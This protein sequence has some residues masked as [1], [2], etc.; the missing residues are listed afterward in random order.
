MGW[1]WRLWV[2]FFLV[3]QG[4]AMVCAG[5]ANGHTA[6]MKTL[7][8][9]VSGALT[10]AFLLGFCFRHEVVLL[11]N[12]RLVRLD[13]L[14]GEASYVFVSGL[15]QEKRERAELEERERAERAEKDRKAALPAAAV[16]VA[17]APGA[18]TDAKTAT[19]DGRELTA[20]EI[21]RL[22]FKWRRN[23]SSDVALSFHNPF[24][25]KVRID[26]VRVQIPAHDGRAAIDRMYE[27]T[28]FACEPLADK[29]TPL[30]TLDIDWEHIVQA[31]EGAAAAEETPFG[32][33][34][35]PPGARRPDVA[36]SITPV[37]VRM[38]P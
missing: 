30:N 5:A 13:R 6:S 36:G 32:T 35:P 8:T 4:A 37:Q 12:N 19:P 34:P 22:E 21:Q 29:W 9:F 2:S 33:P 26:R 20:E 3:V 1:G 28:G 14:T 11:G 10:G 18:D 24:E 17:T 31:K 15:E 16:A 38:S 7:L 27:C 23:G 25:Q